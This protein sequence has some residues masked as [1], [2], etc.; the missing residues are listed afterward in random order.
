[1]ANL[2]SHSL[3]FSK[4]SVSEYFIKP[5]FIQSDIKDI[6]TVRTDIKNSE[7]LDFIDNLEKIT[8][9]YA[10]GTSFTTSTGVTI[11]QKTLSVSDMK[12]EVA[13]NGKAFLNYVKE[14]LLNGDLHG[15]YRKRFPK[16]SILRWYC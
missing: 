8:K 7:K 13:Q 15:W 3:S 1:M 2:M 12:A 9:A 11:T 4:E 10:Q 16:T 6:V 14:S 5:L